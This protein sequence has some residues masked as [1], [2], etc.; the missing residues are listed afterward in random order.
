MAIYLLGFAE[1][2]SNIDPRA[3]ICVIAILLVYITLYERIRRFQKKD[4]P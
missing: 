4:K 2:K 1:L 3:S